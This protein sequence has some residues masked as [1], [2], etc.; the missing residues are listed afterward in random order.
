MRGVKNHQKDLLVVGCWYHSCLVLITSHQQND[1]GRKT[2]VY[3]TAW[4]CARAVA[5]TSNEH[6][7]Y[8]DTLQVF[9]AFQKSIHEKLACPREWFPITFQSSF[10]LNI[11]CCWNFFPL[12]GSLSVSNGSCVIR[13]GIPLGAGWLKNHPWA[14]WILTIHLDWYRHGPSFKGH[15]YWRTKAALF[16]YEFEYDLRLDSHGFWGWI[17]MDFEVGF[18]WFEVG[19]PWFNTKRGP[20]FWRRNRGGHWSTWLPSVGGSGKMCGF[21]QAIPAVKHCSTSWFNVP[22]VWYSTPKWM[23][24][25]GNPY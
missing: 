4:K 17:P 6:H 25:N 24:Y 7:G 16:V 18:P 14:W 20:V 22:Y 8:T 1:W 12:G 15:V 3:P 5:Y 11:T 9:V 19:F 13:G 10:L 21:S 23:V 2:A